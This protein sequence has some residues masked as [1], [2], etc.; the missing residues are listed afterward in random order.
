MVE[1]YTLKKD[2]FQCL[3]KILVSKN[4]NA[5]AGGAIFTDGTSSGDVSNSTFINNNANMGGAIVSYIWM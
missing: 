3:L 4:N 1:Q 2:Q 5:T